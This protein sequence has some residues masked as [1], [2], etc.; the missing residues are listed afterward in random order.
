M[1]K[2]KLNLQALRK[3]KGI[4]QT[5]LA[6]AT[7]VCL[8]YISQLERQ[9]N[10]P[11]LKLAYR[12]ACVLGCTLDDLVIECEEDEGA[13]P[14]PGQMTIEDLADQSWYKGGKASEQTTCT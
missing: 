9:Q 12:I 3:A 10:W 4:T 1:S 7:G 2:I 8:N 11:T 13:T 14:I 6:K 5:E